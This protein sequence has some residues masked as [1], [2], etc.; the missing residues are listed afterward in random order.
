M[1]SRFDL[2]AADGRQFD[3]VLEAFRSIKPYVNVFE[4]SRLVDLFAKHG[5]KEMMFAIELMGRRGWMHLDDLEV[6]LDEAVSRYS[7]A[8]IE[9]AMKAYAKEGWRSVGSLVEF[10]AGR[11]QPKFSDKVNDTKKVKKSYPTPEGIYDQF[12]A[13]RYLSE[14]DVSVDAWAEYFEAAGKDGVIHLFRLKAEYR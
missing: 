10:L 5:Q 14:R 12:S 9:Q 6:L 7:R 3:Q 13:Q 2:S 1:G 4:Q 8:K 11:L